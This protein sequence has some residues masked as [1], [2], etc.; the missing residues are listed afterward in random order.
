MSG[1]E[2]PVFVLRLRPTPDC[3]TPYRALRELLK[4]AL[5]NYGLRCI[6]ITREDARDEIAL[7][8]EQQNSA[9]AE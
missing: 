2:R 5:R 3:T 4:R 9:P 1:I 6:A 8:I 7:D